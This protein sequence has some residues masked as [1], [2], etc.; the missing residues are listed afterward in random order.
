MRDM[1]NAI[2]YGFPVLLENVGQELDP[3]LNPIL[4]K[5]VTKKGNNYTIKLGDKEI[6]YSKNFRFYVTTKLPSPHYTPEVCVM[7]TILNFMATQD[8]LLD[9]MLTKIMEIDEEKKEKERI[10]GLED[11]A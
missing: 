2:S 6:D 5:A 3:Q 9:Q 11:K 10:K 8:G 4:Q 7:V 1:E